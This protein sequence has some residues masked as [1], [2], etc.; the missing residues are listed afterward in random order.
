M[1]LARPD[2]KIESCKTKQHIKGFIINY[3]LGG[4][5]LKGGIKYWS[6]HGN[7]EQNEIIDR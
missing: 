3:K 5:I 1:R 6:Y 7:H 2:T 4:R